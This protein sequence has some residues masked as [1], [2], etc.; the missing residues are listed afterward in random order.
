[1]KKTVIA[2]TSNKQALRRVRAKAGVK[3]PYHVLCD[4]SFLRCAFDYFCQVEKFQLQQKQ[5]KKVKDEAAGIAPGTGGGSRGASRGRAGGRGGGG[6]RG[7]GRG[8]A[9]SYHGS[10]W[11]GHAAEPTPEDNMYPPLRDLVNNALGGGPTFL[12]I[13]EESKQAFIQTT[14]D[15]TGKAAEKDKSKKPAKEGKNGPIKEKPKYVLVQKFLGQLFEN[16][17]SLP[18]RG[19]QEEAH[20]QQQSAT[21]GATGDSTT[22]TTNNNHKKKNAESSTA[23]STPATTTDVAALARNEHKAI[24]DRV[25]GSLLLSKGGADALSLSKEKANAAVVEGMY[26]VGT[27]SHDTRRELQSRC[28]S[29]FAVPTLRFTFNPTLLWLEEGEEKKAA[30]VRGGGTVLQTHGTFLD[31]LRQCFEGVSASPST[32]G[33]GIANA[34]GTRSLIATPIATSV[35]A[36][37]L[38]HVTSIAD[39]A[40]LRSLE[41]GEYFEKAASAGKKRP[42]SDG[43]DGDDHDEAAAPLDG[44]E[45]AEGPTPDP[46]RGVAAPKPAKNIYNQKLMKHL[47]SKGVRV[48]ASAFTRAEGGGLVT[49]PTANDRKAAASSKSNNGGKKS[50][51]TNT[52]SST[53]KGAPGKEHGANPL[54]VKKKKHRE[55]FDFTKA[56]S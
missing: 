22:T 23:A 14:L 11:G 27:N 44:A 54:S 17:P 55:T 49:P 47:Q 33:L 15:P 13:I 40:F 25:I 42:R 24:A 6:G 5:K 39:R 51:T 20:K 37:K 56:S 43:E 26:I 9:G 28:G 12:H 4:A 2:S 48:R 35:S 3:A 50:S 21:E 1:M 46:K 45:S 19:F 36:A 10:Q 7:F 18:P 38:K 32:M 31:R 41:S 30:N 53:K 8:G 29:L 34:S 52:A 16:V